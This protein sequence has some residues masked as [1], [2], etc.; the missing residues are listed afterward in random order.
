MLRGSLGLALSTGMALAACSSSQGAG[1]AGATCAYPAGPYGTRVGEVVDPSLSWQGY[2]DDGT[3]PATVS[4]ESYYDCDGSLGVAA[5]LLDES[6]TWCD[7]C[8][9]EAQTIA[10]D[11]TSSWKSQ[12][13]HLVTL[14]AQ[15]QQ[16][17]P[18]TLDTA[19]SWR[20][21]YALTAGAVC[22]D[23]AWTLKLWGGATGNG[24][25]FPTNVLID[26]R[27]MKIV[28]IQPADLVGTVQN[29][30]GSNGG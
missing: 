14:M 10:P 26:P 28:A 3:T 9:N 27:T 29:L 21:E 25:G 5:L 2:L 16:T 4:L 19:L 15:D 20:N 8:A 30:A 17:N 7:N 6:A 22:A 12:G 13:I 1:K 23:P 11:V 24:N 18:A